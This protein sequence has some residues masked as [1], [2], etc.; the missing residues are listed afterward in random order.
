[1]KLRCRAVGRRRLR[2]PRRE[3][4]DRGACGQAGFRAGRHQCSSGA[5][6]HGPGHAGARTAPR[7]E[8]RLEREGEIASRLK[9]LVRT[10][11]EAAVE[12]SSSRAGGTPGTVETGG[13]GSSRRI[14]VIVSAAVPRSNARRPVS[15]SCRMQPSAKTSERCSLRSPRTCSGAMYPTVPSTTPGSVAGATVVRPA[16]DDA[17][18]V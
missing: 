14:A 9:P 4:A 8:R 6:P 16:P 15:I 10:F 17:S 12:N 2:P 3:H 18:S 7:V 1:M 13:D 11:L 5:D